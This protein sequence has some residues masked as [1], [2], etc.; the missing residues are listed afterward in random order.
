MKVFSTY[1]QL[2]V[3]VTIWALL[4]HALVRADSDAPGA[5]EDLSASRTLAEGRKIFRFDTF[6][7]E[8]FWGG[9][10]YDYIRLSRVLVS[11]ALDPV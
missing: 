8:A 4:G 10:R 6:G 5:R 3:A 7:D 2:A 1:R 11:A 9:I